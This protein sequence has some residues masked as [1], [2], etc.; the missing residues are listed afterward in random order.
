MKINQVQYVIHEE[1]LPI[2]KDITEISD[3]RSYFFIEDYRR[4]RE[5]KVQS[6]KDCHT[7]HE[8]SEFWIEMFE[9]KHP[10]VAIITYERFTFGGYAV[11]VISSE[12]IL[13]TGKQKEI[14]ETLTSL[15]EYFSEI[16]T[17]EFDL[18]LNPSYKTAVEMDGISVFEDWLYGNVFAQTEDR[19]DNS[20]THMK[21]SDGIYKMTFTKD[22]DEYEVRKFVDNFI[23]EDMVSWLKQ[24][25][26]KIKQ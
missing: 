24:D 20:A 11:M 4:E 12:D 5:R 13:T 3:G 16:K 2:L 18:R 26:P 21:V 25:V 1:D 6:A 23:E 8:K 17:I 9:S 10:D 19:C 14:L 7:T 15:F 22:V